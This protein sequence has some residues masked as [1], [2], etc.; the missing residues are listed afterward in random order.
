MIQFR[1][2]TQQ[3]APLLASIHALSLS[4]PWT[5]SAFLALLQNP[6]YG[7]WLAV[8]RGVA[9]GFIMVSCIPPEAEILT[10]AVVPEWRRQHIGQGLL[11]HFLGYCQQGIAH[12]FLE[13]DSTNQPAIKLY[14]KEGFQQI[15][16]RTDY[17]QYP[18]GAFSD[19]LVMRLEISDMTVV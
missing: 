5:E 7:G 11:R 12:V 1:S 4:S 13:V 18:S 8:I 10:F 6:C 17:Y 2:I 16:Q 14:Q 15:G 9:V 19:A 3:D